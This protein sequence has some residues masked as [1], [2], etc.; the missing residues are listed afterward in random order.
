MDR[1]SAEIQ[2]EK[3]CKIR[4]RYWEEDGRFRDAQ[5]VISGAA[6]VNQ[7]RT[8]R[9]FRGKP[10][11]YLRVVTMARNIVLSTV[12]DMSQSGPDEATPLKKRRREEETAAQR[13]STE[14]GGL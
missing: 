6:G 2:L 14:T 11:H 9:R 5:Q 1:T 8:I 7:V 4:L 10:E 3:G 12:D 13:H